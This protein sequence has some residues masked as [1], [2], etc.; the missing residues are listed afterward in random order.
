MY[1]YN[2]Y[3]AC[4]SPLRCE[5]KKCTYDFINPTPV[6]RFSKDLALIRIIAEAS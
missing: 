4:N 3:V 6:P 1:S 2:T 5:Y